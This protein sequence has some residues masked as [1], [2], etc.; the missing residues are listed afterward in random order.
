MA[1]DPNLDHYVTNT[2]NIPPTTVKC[3]CG[4]IYTGPDCLTVMKAHMDAKNAVA[5]E[6]DVQMFEVLGSRLRELTDDIAKM[7]TL[8]EAA[9]GLIANA[10]WDAGTGDVELPK[11]TGW[12][13]AAVRWR[14]DYFA[15]SSRARSSFVWEKISIEKG[16]P[17]ET[18]LV[19]ARSFRYVSEWCLIH[20]INARSPRVMWVRELRHLEGIKDVYYVDLGT[21][22][23][24]LRVLLE[25]LKAMGYIKPLL[26]PN[27]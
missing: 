18:I 6:N 23:H 22:S 15:L 4:N 17:S 19:I 25:R 20:G 14:E 9:W 7:S 5:E 1:V 26:T 8:L 21:D 11:T 3:K 10:G 27:I 16:E 13:E 24:E 2:V 12:H